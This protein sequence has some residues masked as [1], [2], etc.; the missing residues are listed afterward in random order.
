[1]FDKAG[2]FIKTLISYGGGP[3]EISGPIIGM[4]AGELNNILYLFAPDAIWT[5]T[6]EEEFTGKTVHEYSTIYQ[7]SLG[8]GRFAS[9][10]YICRFRPE[11][12]GW[13]YLTLTATQ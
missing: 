11:V 4:Q 5:Y 8:N 6:L 12:S 9:V 2:K 1:M 3:G 13:D 10:C 7:A